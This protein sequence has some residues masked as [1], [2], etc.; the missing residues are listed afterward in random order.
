MKKA[1]IAC[2]ILAF[3]VSLLFVPVVLGHAPLGVKDN[4]N[5]NSATVIPDPTKSWALYYALNADGD[6]QYYTFNITAGQRVHVILL[7]SME[8]NDS[9]FLPEIAILAE[10]ITNQGTTISKVTIPNGYS[11]RV[12]S[13]GQPKPT[14][15]PFSPSSFDGLSDTAFNAPTSGQYYIAVFENSSA[16][17]GGHYGLAIGDK[18]TYTIDEWVLLPLNLLSIYAWEGQTLLAM[19][20]PM[21]ATVVIGTVLVAWH[22]RKQGKTRSLYSWV[23]AIAGSILVGSGADTLLQLL[24]ANSNAFGGIQ[25]LI[26]LMFV[27]L[28]IILGI[29]ALRFSLGNP[30]NIGILKRITFLFIGVVALFL[31]AGLFIGPV[32]AIATSVM[33]TGLKKSTIVKTA[34]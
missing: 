25:I 20:A 29:I 3:L 9:Q 12:I 24:I 10:N 22:L 27:A 14:Y 15:E 32:V 19:I 4:E 16:H 8:S 33:P 1:L 13:S 26:T 11:A 18:E 31:L 7:K 30:A 34:S 28:P 2:G 21:I 23:G 17:N 5:I 6:P